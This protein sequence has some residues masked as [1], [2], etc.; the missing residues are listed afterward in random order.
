MPVNQLTTSVPAWES[1]D[2][3][4]FSEVVARLHD[5]TAGTVLVIALD[6]GAEQLTDELTRALQTPGRTVLATSLYM[7]GTDADGQLDDWLSRATTTWRFVLTGAPAAIMW[8][9]ARLFTAGAM[10]EEVHSISTAAERGRRVFCAHCGTVQTLPVSVGDT[11]Q[12]TCGVQVS[13][14]YHYSVRQGGY[15]AFEAE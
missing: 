6:R 8:A 12:C 4:D 1:A 9:R 3:G 13:V 14:Y 2:T 11:Y 15:L 7:T 10:P 5:D